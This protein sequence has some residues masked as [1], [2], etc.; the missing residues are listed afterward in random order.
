[1]N[2]PE[3]VSRE[4]WTEAR[5]RLL[6]EEKEIT[7]RHD[8]LN[9]ERRRLPMVR[10]EKDYAFEGP[11]GPATLADLFGD[12][13]Q[14]IVQHV[15]YGPEW[16]AACPGCTASIDELS[17]AVLTHVRSRDTAFALVSRAPLAKLEAYRTSR[18]WT[19]P[20][21]SSYGSDFNY[22]YQATLDASRPQLQ[23]NFRP[24][25]EVV[26]DEPSTELP[27]FSTFLRDG[28][29]I[30]HTYSSYARGT[31]YVGNAY[32]LLDLT[33]FGRSEDWEEPKGRAPRLHGADP[34]FTD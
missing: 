26:A 7:K 5:L 6:A 24:E 13:S 9:A 10:V 8:A 17:E 32:T 20:W 16:D 21:Y 11:K 12:S 34:T 33:A 15:M 31:E 23:Y 19:A 2:L 30:F 25:P 27:G 18:G 14:L 22:D 4:Q 28:D 29:E 3:V 1:M